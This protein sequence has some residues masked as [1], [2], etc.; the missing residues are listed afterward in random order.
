MLQEGK[1]VWERQ[2]VGCVHSRGRLLAAGVAKQ[3]RRKQC[4]T[5]KRQYGNESNPFHDSKVL[6][7][8]RDGLPSK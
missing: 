1:V 6:G 2:W 7:E 8:R 4:Y 5:G 3:P